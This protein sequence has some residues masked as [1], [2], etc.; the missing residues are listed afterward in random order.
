M[1][2]HDRFD[3]LA[4]GHVLGGLSTPEAAEFRSHLLSCRDCRMRVAELRDMA[5]TM[6][7]AE[8]EERAQLRIKT[9]TEQRRDEPEEPTPAWW[10]RP[11]ALTAGIASAVLVVLGLMFW[12]LHLRTVNVTARAAVEFD[13]RVLAGLAEGDLVEV[14]TSPG[15]TGL[16]ARTDDG[17]SFTLAGLPEVDDERWQV[18]WLRTRSEG[19]S[20]RL[21]SA[22]GAPGG[23]LATNLDAAVPLDLVVSVEDDL[24]TQAPNRGR[25]LASASFGGG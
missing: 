21:V 3:G 24:T 23:R 8:R 22:D 20:K 12:N 16:V 10:R 7:A 11:G 14:E 2:D 18:V 19:W 9:E 4:V 1:P 13:E 6:A 15:V 17:V 25:A 5:A